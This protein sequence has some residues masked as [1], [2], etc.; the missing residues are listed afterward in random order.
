MQKTRIGDSAVWNLDHSCASVFA[1]DSL[2]FA[3]ELAHPER[4]LLEP[5]FQGNRLNDISLFQLSPHPPAA[6]AGETIIDAYTRGADLG[7]HVRADSISQCAAP[8]GLEGH[9]TS[10]RYRGD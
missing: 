5:V 2:T 1:R 9:S 10:K 8:I 6:P 7:R 3:V 4:G